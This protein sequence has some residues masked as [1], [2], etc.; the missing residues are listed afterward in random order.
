M[1]NLSFII[2]VLLVS[3]TGSHQS[4]EDQ[5]VQNLLSQM[6]LEEKVGQLNQRTSQ[7]EMTGP[8]PE[9]S[10]DLLED[11]KKGN[12]GSM[13]NV[14]G[15]A[16]TY[17]AQKI[18]VENS[19][20]GIPLLFAYD[21]IHGYQTMM[22]IPLGESASWNPQLVEESA[23][24]IAEETAAAG[25]HWTFAP[26]IDVGR[27][28]R[29]GRVMEGAGEDPFLTS[30]LAVARVKGFQG[31]D[32][33][34]TNTIAA[35]AK[36]FAAYA[37][38]EAGREYNTV[39]IGDETLH[40][41]VFPPFKATTEAGVATVMN[42]FNT[43]QGLPATA[44]SYLQ[45]DLLKGQWNFDGFVVSDW[46][47]IGEIQTHGA[48]SDLKEAAERAIKAGSDMDMEASAYVKYLA[49]LVE[50]RRV[51]EALVDDAVR[52][53][54]HLKYRMGLFRDPFR[55]CNEVKEKEVIGSQAI[56]E[57][58]RK[59]ARESMVLLKNEEQLLPLSKDVKSIAV[60]GPL[61]NDK[62]VPLGSWRAKAITN[63]AVS[64]FEGIQNAVS[65]DVSVQYS[66]GCNLAINERSF[67]TE[68]T[69]S[70]T[71]QA[72]FNDALDL[73]KNS[74]VVVLVI[75]EDCFQSGEGRSQTDITL[76]GQQLNLF[77][78]IYEVNKNVVVVL[79]NGRPVAIPELAQKAPAI[80]ETW[81][82]GNQAGHAIADVLFGAY[83]PSGKLP[84]T[85]PRNVGQ[86]PIYYNHKNTGRP[87]KSDEHVFWSHYTDSPNSPLYPFGYG[88]SYTTFE[89]S[90]LK[91]NKNEMT[92]LDSVMVSVK[93]KNIGERIGEE[94][95]QLYIRDLAAT[96]ARPVLELKGFEKIELKAGEEKVLTFSLSAKELGYYLP[97]GSFQFEKGAFKVFVG[98]N[99]QEL[100]E[101][102]FIVR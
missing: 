79:M 75:G 2:L 85:F 49:E 34:E 86:C 48:A 83:N 82:A 42:A 78:A 24:A 69:L 25:V 35:C 53:V 76:K 4:K 55:Y 21:V 3:C 31:N 6:T 66:K 59:V 63:S 41:I 52:R 26:M 44:N 29:W 71:E 67:Y 98:T 94:V 77:Q 96:Y 65:A 73:A 100:L 7:W 8:A 38:A 5:F 11:L 12:V 20:L 64:V 74:E 61:A 39:E 30:A 19:R 72:D 23:K 51:D 56:H 90:D 46:N 87:N 43:I 68:L 40:N 80:L 45:R 37:F 70:E 91:L 36:H 84:M 62:D 28:A 17:E 47:S 97:N 81:F 18:V 60:I 95:V 9:S 93:V 57:L 13:L 92:T 15:V 33:E 22:P 54:L 32:L 27:D 10:S 102:S 58:S 101:A 1:K 88:L 14:A 16:E 50:Q 89:Y 99:S